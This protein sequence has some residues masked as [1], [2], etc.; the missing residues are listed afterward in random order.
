MKSLSIED[1]ETIRTFVKYLLKN[2]TKVAED[3]RIGGH[4]T[5]VNANG[6]ILFDDEVG[7]PAPEMIARY[8]VNAR[9]KAER[10]RNSPFHV[11]SW[12]SRNPDMS[13]WGGS[14]R[15]PALGII[16]SFSGLTEEED[17]ALCAHIALH[18]GWANDNCL[19]ST[20]SQAPGHD[21][22]YMEMVAF[23]S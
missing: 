15:L 3:G 22:A 14:V 5:I 13:Q 19:R 8:R 21:D 20:L 23:A 1:Q 11:L 6:A 17:A 9:E 7:I 10:L 4:L 12:Q 2:R 18:M 16:I